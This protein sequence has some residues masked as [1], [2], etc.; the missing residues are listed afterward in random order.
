MN[1]AL[2]IIAAIELGALRFGILTVLLVPLWEFLRHALASRPR[3][4]ANFGRPPWRSITFSRRS[5]KLSLTSCLNTSSRSSTPKSREDEWRLVYVHDFRKPALGLM[6]R[7][8]KDMLV[9]YV[10]IPLGMPER[11][12]SVRLPLGEINCGPF[13]EQLAKDSVNRFSSSWI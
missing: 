6:F 8:S 12:E 9:P 10:E 11:D 3:T 5:P 2:E 1:K 4:S 13:H 7:P